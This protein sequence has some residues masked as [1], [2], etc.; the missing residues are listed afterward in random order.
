MEITLEVGFYPQ[1]NAAK[2]LGLEALT[3]EDENFA[4]DL[5]EKLGELVAL[6][7]FCSSKIA[8]EK[9]EVACNQAIEEIL[10]KPHLE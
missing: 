10:E 1:L 2:R 9:A 5:I 6:N 7:K 4:L 3:E 8:I